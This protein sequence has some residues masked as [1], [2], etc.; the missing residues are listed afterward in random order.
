LEDACEPTSETTETSALLPFG[1]QEA[2]IDRM[3]INTKASWTKMCF[4]EDGGSE[5]KNGE[6]DIGGI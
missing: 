5:K 6:E 3:S 1:F 4:G 2:G